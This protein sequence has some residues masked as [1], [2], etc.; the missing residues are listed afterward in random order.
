MRSSLRSKAALPALCAALLAGCAAP[1]P[2]LPRHTG[3]A[4][5]A[6]YALAT[7]APPAAA[8]RTALAALPAKRIAMLTEPVWEALGTDERSQIEAAHEVR[9]VPPQGYGTIIDV[10]GAD[11][12]TPG[13]NAGAAIGGAVASAAYIDNAFRGGN[14]SAGGHLA[15]GL[16]GAALGSSMDRAPTS[17]FQ[18]RYTVKQG[19]GEIQYFDEVKSTSFRHSVGVCVLLPSLTLVSQQV[20]QQTVE[21]ARSR[22]LKTAAAGKQ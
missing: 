20:C 17:Q 12:S 22:F 15:I 3:Q 2:D 11:Q 4:Q 9:L 18:F 13:T 8:P 6:G 1:A 5:E 16:L 21:S 14:Y 19:D 7:T 10:Q